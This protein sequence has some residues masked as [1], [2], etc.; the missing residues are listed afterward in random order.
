MTYCSQRA[1]LFFGRA[2]T[3]DHRDVRCEKPTVAQW[4][5][6]EVLKSRTLPMSAV[7]SRY[8]VVPLPYKPAP[9]AL[10]A[11]RATWKVVGPASH[12]IADRARMASQ[13]CRCR[14]GPY[15]SIG[16]SPGIRLLPSPGR[17]RRSSIAIRSNPNVVANCWT[18]ERRS[19]VI[20]FV[21]TSFDRQKQASRHS[22]KAPCWV[23]RSR[24]TSSPVPCASA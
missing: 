8:Y 19:L 20:S 16:R 4:V 21:S 24:L 17:S 23:A 9:V 3:S 2:S 5:M 22:V 13:T 1:F 15:R 11:L 7:L 18:T 12:R 10:G 6:G 14:S